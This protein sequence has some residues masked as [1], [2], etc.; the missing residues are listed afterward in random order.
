MIEVEDKLAG[1]IARLEGATEGSR[2]LDA[3]L[4]VSTFR[5]ESWR[6]SV[7]LSDSRRGWV[8]TTYRR[9][10]GKL[11]YGTSKA[12]HYTRSVDDALRLVEG[13]L[14]GWDYCLSKGGYE[15]A[16]ASLSP[17]R[18][19]TEAMA[20]MATPALALCLA[21]CRALLAQDPRP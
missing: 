10:D 8:I 18:G 4:A 20:T 15:P 7:R 17:P 12:Q 9:S 13:L 3:L 5:P 11:T 1:L 21:L 16:E 6:P 2:E 19:V 14:P